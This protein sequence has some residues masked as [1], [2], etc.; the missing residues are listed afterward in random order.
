[1]TPRTRQRRRAGFT[2]LEII[3]AVAIFSIGI[4][5]VI[6]IFRPGLDTLRL[7]GDVMR[8]VRLAEEEA[9]RLKQDAASLPDAIVAL[10]PH[11]EVLPYDPRDVTP[12]W[13][14]ASWQPDSVALPRVVL[15]ERI[16]IQRQTRLALPTFKF[17]PD[18]VST[19]L[20][21]EVS[22]GARVLHVESAALFS[23]GTTVRMRHP[24]FDPGDLVRSQ[25]DFSLGVVLRVDAAA[26]TI[27]VQVPVPDV[28]QGQMPIGSKVYGPGLVVIYSTDE[29]RRVPSP[30]ALLAERGGPNELTSYF[31]EDT[32]GEVLFNPG[33]VDRFVKLDYTWA[34][35]G[36][37]LKSE[38]RVNDGRADL[39]TPID[40]PPIRRPQPGVY[41]VPGALTV[42]IPVGGLST[43]FAT[44]GDPK[45]ESVNRPIGD[46]GA[47]RVEAALIRDLDGLVERLNTA[48]SGVLPN[49]AQAFVALNGD[50]AR[51]G[52]G[53]LLPGHYEVVSPDLHFGTAF[54]EFA[55][56]DAGRQVKMDYRVADWG[57]LREDHTV[58]PSGEVSLRL[59]NLKGPT[60][61]VPPRTPVPQPVVVHAGEPHF[62]VA[63]DPTTGQMLL[64]NRD[65][66]VDYHRGLVTGLAP[67]IGTRLRFFYR[68][69]QDWLVQVF[70]P[71]ALYTRG[72]MVQASQFY[73][74]DERTMQFPL[75]VVGS[76]LLVDYRATS[77]DFVTGEVVQLRGQSPL[78]IG[79][80]R[81]SVDDG[82]LMLARG[83]SVR[84]RVVWAVD[85]HTL[86]VPPAGRETEG[87][88]LLNA[89]WMSRQ[90]ELFITRREL[91]LP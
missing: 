67:Y 48:F 42:S 63:V 81:H 79:T 8:A 23:V 10:G 66:V 21:T 76:T 28:G 70:K 54:L 6:L 86:A 45:S 64:D 69:K 33:P 2:V 60:D 83:V 1:M 36:V 11:G 25:F 39:L 15:G 7:S 9:E 14:N 73:M 53:A 75:D 34:K 24:D 40:T 61:R 51:D 68:S 13:G 56:S 32:T 41:W 55:P 20:L 47:G 35:A 19:N 80:L 12:D 22:P 62:V 5:A 88:Q 78:S 91:G 58:E 82:G 17:T 49:S 59:D 37:P 85:G 38:A 65:F 31:L 46:T 52:L 84:V 16:N 30:G 50:G 27:E 4:V 29:M 87:R 26:N 72:Q 77:G 3:V 74:A 43:D 57:L 18:H 90:V 44:L 71:R 89:R